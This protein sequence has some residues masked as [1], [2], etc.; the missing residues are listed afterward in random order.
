MKTKVCGHA[1]AF[2]LA[3]PFSV[4]SAGA[5]PADQ[6]SERESKLLSPQ[7]ELSLAL[8]QLKKQKNFEVRLAYE[9]GVAGDGSHRP[10]SSRQVSKHVGFVYKN[11]MMHVPALRAYRTPTKGVCYKGDSVRPGGVYSKRDRQKEKGGWKG[12]VRSAGIQGYAAGAAASM[13]QCF[14]FPS[15][16]LADAMKYVK[17]ARR[18]ARSLFRDEL[19]QKK[20]GSSAPQDNAKARPKSVAARREEAKPRDREGV[21]EDAPESSSKTTATNS[22]VKSTVAGSKVQIIR[23]TVPPKKA[24]KKRVACGGWG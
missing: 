24:Q 22:T 3:L 19:D 13:H 7:G 1:I 16:L 14:Y 21:P 18:V 23:V 10:T 12:Y 5:S 8:K 9:R 15:E 6:A 20:T 11:K 17:S 4:L 2:L